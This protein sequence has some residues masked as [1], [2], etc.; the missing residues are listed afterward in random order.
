MKSKCVLF[1]AASIFFAIATSA[2]DKRAKIQDYINEELIIED[3]WAGQS[4]T[5]IKQNKDYYIRHKIF[6]S[7]IPV[8]DSAKYE[9]EFTSAYQLTFSGGISRDIALKD[10]K[11]AFLMI[12]D[13]K[14][15]CLYLNGL[16]VVT[17]QVASKK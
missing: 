3:N 12:V 4:V 1:L 9:V 11:N 17:R 15:L 14:G 2:Q 6:G 13:D 5:L 16:K 10:H 7:G 8:I